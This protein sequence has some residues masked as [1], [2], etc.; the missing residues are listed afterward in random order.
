M[1][2]SVRIE[3]TICTCESAHTHM[4][5]YSRQF[6]EPHWHRRR[7]F[8]AAATER[9]APREK[10]VVSS[11]GDLGWWLHSDGES[12]STSVG[13][14]GKSN[15]MAVSPLTSIVGLLGGSSVSTSMICRELASDTVLACSVVSPINT[16]NHC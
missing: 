16:K 14:G 6:F 3:N 15:S 4:Y 7:Y 12:G 11:A 13:V 2:L 5:R 10:P 8:V 9:L 1:K